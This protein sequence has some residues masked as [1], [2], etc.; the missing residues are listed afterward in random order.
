M[1]RTTATDHIQNWRSYLLTVMSA[2]RLTVHLVTC[3]T[4]NMAMV[5]REVLTP[6]MLA[7]QPPK[8]RIKITAPYVTSFLN[9]N[10]MR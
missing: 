6:V 9:A 4:P 7:A 5:E 1:L 3:I 8:E 10:A 2:Y